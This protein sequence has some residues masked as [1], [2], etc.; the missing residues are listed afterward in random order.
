MTKW[1]LLC[2]LCEHREDPMTKVM[3][4]VSDMLEFHTASKFIIGI[5]CDPKYRWGN[6]TYGYKTKGFQEL[7]IVVKNDDAQII[8]KL[9]KAAIKVYRR[10][11]PA[12]MLVNPNGH[13]FCG[14]RNPGGEG[15]YW[16]LASHFLYIAIE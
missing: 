14:N 6:P 13:Q 15:A 1:S 10:Y 11:N 4:V 9:E 8:A 5:T 7:R 16:G 12:G 3:N 2:D